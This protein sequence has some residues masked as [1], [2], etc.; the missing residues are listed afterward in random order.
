MEFPDL[1]VGGV[2]ID[3]SVSWLAECNRRGTD[4]A[5]GP[6]YALCYA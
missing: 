6:D 5:S 4:G 3:Q 2:S 1:L